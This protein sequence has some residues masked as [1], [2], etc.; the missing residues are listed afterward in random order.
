[1]ASTRFNHHYR[2]VAPNAAA[3]LRVSVVAGIADHWLLGIGGCEF[4]AGAI[5]KEAIERS[6]DLLFYRVR[7][8]VAHVVVLRTGRRYR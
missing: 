7:T 4:A 8:A 1:M 2:V 3:V 6:L 5:P